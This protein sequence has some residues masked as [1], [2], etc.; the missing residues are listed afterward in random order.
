[1]T[2]HSD[3]AH[4][5][6]QLEPESTECLTGC[7]MFYDGATIYSYGYHFPIAKHVR[8][9]GGEHVVLFTTDSYSSST[10][11]HKSHTSGACSH[12]N[13]FQVPCV[14]AST[15]AV[16]K[17]NYKAMKKALRERLIAL[18]RK[19]TALDWHYKAYIDAL[20]KLNSY[21][22]AFKLGFK[23]MPLP[24]APDVSTD[25]ERITELRD[26][27]ENATGKD[28]GDFGGYHG[29]LEYSLTPSLIHIWRSRR[30]KLCK[31]R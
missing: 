25:A 21:T 4:R 28:C 14:T 9:A 20:K 26:S 27:I 7:N 5:W 17:S 30:S 12:L 24:E 3:V 15:K 22:A 6:A 31:S 8:D 13:V 11:T 18:G 1:M 23:A 29:W 19:R 2:S 16:H 10:S